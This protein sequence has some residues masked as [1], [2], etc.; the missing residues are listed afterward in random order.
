MS[1]NYCIHLG[2][3]DKEERKLFY[4]ALDFKDFIQYISHTSGAAHLRKLSLTKLQIDYSR[5]TKQHFTQYLEKLESTGVDDEFTCMLNAYLIKKIPV[6]QEIEDICEGCEYDELSYDEHAM[7][8]GL[9]D[10]YDIEKYKF[11]FEHLVKLSCDFSEAEMYKKRYEE[12]QRISLKLMDSNKE[13]EEENNTLKKE[14]DK[15]K[16][17]N[18]SLSNKLSSK[19]K[20]IEK[21][22]TKQT[23]RIQESTF[24]A[25]LNTQIDGMSF[26]EVMHLLNQEEENAL[27]NADWKQAKMTLAAKYALLKQR[28]DGE[29]HE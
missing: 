3:L 16:K 11:E 27:K 12:L 21:M 1:D 22:K 10:A 23:V 7:L 6:M 26:D 2:N 17:E 13:Y 25:L 4:K 28:E 14:L 5:L 8:D 29:A 15:A 20:M 24:N 9:R 18:N 19:E